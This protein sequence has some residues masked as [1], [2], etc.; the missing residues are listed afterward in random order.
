MKKLMHKIQTDDNHFIDL[1]L[2]ILYAFSFLLR[3]PMQITNVPMPRG[4]HKFKTS[5]H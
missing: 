5:S 1:Y 4:H 2:Y 3:Q